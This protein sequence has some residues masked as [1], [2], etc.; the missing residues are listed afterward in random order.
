MY[1]ALS[2]FL[3]RVSDS[4]CVHSLKPPGLKQGPL[5]Q[6]VGP[7]KHLVKLHFL[8]EGMLIYA[9]MLFIKC[10]PAIWI[11]KEKN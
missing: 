1:N 4:K 10:T 9:N 7:R 8:P 2:G 5:D 3:S 6:D 11:L